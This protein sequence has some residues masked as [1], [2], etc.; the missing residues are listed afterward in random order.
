VQIGKLPWEELNKIIKNNKGFLREEVRIRSGIGEDCSVVNFG[1]YECVLSTDPITGAENNIGRLA[2]HI[3]SNDVASCGVNPLGILVT[4]L[5]PPHIELEKVKEI[6]EEIDEE[7]KKLKLEIL[8]GHTEVTDAVNKIIVSCTV[9]GKIEAGRAIST[10]GAQLGDD[11]IV[12]KDL[13]IEGT[14]IIVNDYYS[15]AE[16]IL[17]EDELKEAKTYTEKLSVVKE[18][19]IGGEFG[20]NSMH[21]ITEGGI[22]GALWEVAEGSGVGFRLYKDKLPI[23]N[24]TKKLCKEFSI[25]PLRFISS[26]SMLITC[27]RGIELVKILK[28]NGID[29]CIVGNIIEKDKVL[30][31]NNQEEKVVPQEKDELFKLGCVCKRC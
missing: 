16:K 10:S 18:G 3:N 1:D 5:I 21:D 25:D 30:V 23:T 15:K 28:D 26:G 4:I 7:A 19:V 14:A 24:I 27:K 12:T 22:L 9:I 20:V 2:V 29:A 11:I 13:C 6:M 31:E 8:G 17:D